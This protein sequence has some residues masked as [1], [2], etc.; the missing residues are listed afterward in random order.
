MALIHDVIDSDVRF[1]IDPVT[2]TISNQESKKL[3]LTRGDHNS[4]RFTFEI[5]R[6]VE[7]HDMSLC[8]VV[9]IHFINTDSRTREEMADIYEPDD[10]SLLD[11][12]DQLFTFSWLIERTATNFAGPLAFAIEFQCVVDG[13]VVYSWRTAA[14]STITIVN[15]INNDNSTEPEVD[16]LP[17]DIYSTIRVATVASMIHDVIDSDVR[18]VIDP[19]TRTISN[20]DSKKLM[21]IRGDHKS[22][23]FTFQVPRYIEGHD[24]SL[25]NVVRVHYINTNTKTRSVIAD[26][27]EPTD[28]CVQAGNIVT[29]SWLIGRSAT[30]FAGTLAFSIEFQCVIGNVI[31]YSWHTGV[32]N[33]IAISDG[34]NNAEVLNE[35]YSDILTIWWERLYS[36][37]E[38]PI[39]IVTQD[40][41][42]DP[43]FS[44]RD[45]TLYI[46]ED[47]PT[48]EE[49][50][51]VVSDMR[52][53][54]E[55]LTEHIAHYE[56]LDTNM[57]EHLVKYTKLDA[58]I[59]KHFEDFGIILTRLNSV[60]ARL[61]NLEIG[62]GS[63]SGSGSESGGD[64]GGGD[65]TCEH[66]WVESIATDNTCT[67]PAIQKYV[68]GKCDIE[69]PFE[70]S[71]I[72]RPALGHNWIEEVVI[73]NTCTTPAYQKYRCSRCNEGKQE[74]LTAYPALGHKWSYYPDEDADVTGW[75]RKCNTCNIIETNII[76]GCTNGGDHIWLEEVVIEPTCTTPAYQKCRCHVCGEVKQEPIGTSGTGH[77]FVESVVVD[78]TCTTPAIQKYICT[79]C[80]TEKPFEES[81]VIRPALGHSWSDAIYDEVGYYAPTCTEPGY[82]KYKCA[83]CGG[84]RSEK[85]HILSHDTTNVVIAPTCT[86]QGYT[87]TMCTRIGCDYR[88]T[89]PGSYVAA[90]G[91]T[92]VNGVCSACG[93]VYPG[94]GTCN[95]AMVFDTSKD[96]TCTE[97]GYVRFRCSKCN[98]T[99]ETVI[100][101]AGHTLGSPIYDVVG[102]YKPTCITPGYAPSVCSVCKAEVW[103]SV[104]ATNDHTWSDAIY[105]AVGYYEP[106]CTEPGYAGFVC[107]KCG[108]EKSEKVHILGHAYTDIVTAPTC[109]EQGYT[110]K[111][112]T[113]CGYSYVVPGSQTPATG[114]HSYNAK[115]TP[116]T[117]TAGGYTTY[118][119][120]MCAHSYI[121][122]ETDPNGHDWGVDGGWETITPATC[123]DKGKEKHACRT[124][125]YTEEREIA[126]SGH[127]YVSEVIDP[128]CTAGGYTTYTCSVCSDS[129]TSDEK[130]AL[131]HAAGEP[132]LTR[133]PTCTVPAE[134]AE[135][136]MLCGKELDRYEDDG[137]FADHIEDGGRVTTE[138][139]CTTTGIRTYYCRECD[140]WVRN[141]VIDALGHDYKEEPADPNN[142]AGDGASSDGLVN[143]CTRCGDRNCDG[144]T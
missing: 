5:P 3:V 111:K 124:C 7:G 126:A 56:S 99:E 88:T 26:V 4:E 83:N 142:Y 135:Y 131:G 73:D 14:N 77:N 55:T 43:G 89:V 34:I 69:K 2:R 54:S 66:V 98:H 51:K 49:I 132:V 16:E 59:S 123:V 22:E 108:G 130:E 107:T 100:K 39:E 128:T 92:Y 50:E 141:E 25:C 76:Y 138:A 117:C 113:R 64:V 21:L 61:R 139:T 63:G 41:L 125:G 37:T 36:S 79:K 8:N 65:S 1:I 87:V 20:Q 45:N 102:A 48:L 32:N 78:N 114:V 13:T 86:E 57:S 12:N 47:D 94:D 106:T 28:M 97:N 104:P 133:E 17:T 129:Y 110:T 74:E 134:Y 29:F 19:V 42:D 11:T 93:K 60:E 140:T 31:E 27:Y 84:E 95:H 44:A 24:M 62:S 116:S 18:F 118:T 6:F 46:L 122:D 109:T 67:A 53:F 80:G 90:T 10:A 72:I 112:C 9:R 82:A 68:C 35:E 52:K 23:R 38:L 70:N 33:T 81:D 40:M 75:S 101:S 127:S 15:G 85:V 71:D 121:S 103:D 105:D 137:K 143:V 58:N 144:H 91:H 30:T 120:K 136:C 115:V 96:P 119:C